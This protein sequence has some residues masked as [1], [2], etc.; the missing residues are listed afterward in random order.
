MTTTMRG[1]AQSA[2]SVHGC[3]FLRVV[4]AILALSV[5]SVVNPRLLGAEPAD[6]ARLTI[7]DVSDAFSTAIQF[8]SRDLATPVMVR[9]L[10]GAEMIA[11]QIHRIGRLLDRPV[12]WANGR[13]PMRFGRV[14]REAT[15]CWFAR[16]P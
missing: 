7:R 10:G 15:S 12:R 13:S 8:V 4:L 6:F 14:V 16:P 9:L 11:R 2:A 1:K 3:E 5:M